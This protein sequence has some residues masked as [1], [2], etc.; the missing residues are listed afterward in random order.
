[1]TKLAVA[2]FWFGTLVVCLYR[3]RQG[4]NVLV[5]TPALELGR[6]SVSEEVSPEELGTLWV[7]PIEISSSIGQNLGYFEL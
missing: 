3:R 5:K 1:M 6:E 2:S 7:W 4:R